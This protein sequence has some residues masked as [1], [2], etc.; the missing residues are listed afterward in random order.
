M[1]EAR[2][3]QHPD[4][5]A[6]EKTGYPW[7]PI[8]VVTEISEADAKKFCQESF[9][10]FWAFIMASSPSVAAGFIDDNQGDFLEWRMS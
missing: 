8:K 3:L 9:E 7:F 5:T 1:N 6:A 4:I 2:D 10:D